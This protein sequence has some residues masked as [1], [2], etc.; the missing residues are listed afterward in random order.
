MISVSDFAFAVPKRLVETEEFIEADMEG[1]VR[2][3]R[4]ETERSQHKRAGVGG[5]TEREIDEKHRGQRHV[6]GHQNEQRAD[7][8]AVCLAGDRDHHV[9]KIKQPDRDSLNAAGR[10]REAEE[11]GDQGRGK[12][13]R[14]K[15]ICAC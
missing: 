12:G 9:E 6:R 8:Q 13:G 5:G 15:G 14:E 3:E 7:D 2:G 4:E 11:A 10:S 1:E